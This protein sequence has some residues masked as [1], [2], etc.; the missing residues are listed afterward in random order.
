MH[1]HSLNFI[2]QAHNTQQ[3]LNDAKVKP[4]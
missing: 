4:R 1:T 3:S 2:T